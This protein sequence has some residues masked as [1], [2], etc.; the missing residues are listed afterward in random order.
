MQAAA[1]EPDAA[2]LRLA[3]WRTFLSRSSSIRTVETD[4]QYILDGVDALYAKLFSSRTLAFVTDV[5]RKSDTKHDA[6]GVSSGIAKGTVNQDIAYSAGTTT[7]CDTRD[8]L[9]ACLDNNRPA[10][11]LM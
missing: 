7:K 6:L 9:Q 1:P 2:E 11:R 5:E 3:A 4:E 10:L 8:G